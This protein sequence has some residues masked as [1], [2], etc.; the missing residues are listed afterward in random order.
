MPLPTI[1]QRLRKAREEFLATQTEAA[2]HFGSAQTTISR[3]E[4]HSARNLNLF[5]LI[6][7]S[8]LCRMSVMELIDI[9]FTGGHI[10]IV[11]GQAPTLNKYNQRLQSAFPDMQITKFNSSVRAIKY[12]SENPVS[13]VITDYIMPRLNGYELIKQLQATRANPHTPAI[14]MTDKAPKKLLKQLASTRSTLFFKK[15]EPKTVFINLVADVLRF[16]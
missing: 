6:Q 16:S 4:A 2:N 12:L 11:G 3:I 15:S 10:V 7:H 9:K 13:L 1:G 14:L 8:S 5:K